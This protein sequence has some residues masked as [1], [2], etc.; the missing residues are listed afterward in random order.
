MYNYDIYIYIHM[1]YNI[2]PTITIKVFAATSIIR[3]KFSMRTY[4]HISAVVTINK[5]VPLGVNFRSETCSEH[6]NFKGGFY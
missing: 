3:N 6:R 4:F 5:S 2:T 1:L